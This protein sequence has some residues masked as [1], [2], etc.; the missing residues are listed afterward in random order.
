MNFAKILSALALSSFAIVTG[1]TAQTASTESTASEQAA[2]KSCTGL[3]QSQCEAD[4][5][6]MEKDVSCV[7][8]CT[9]NEGCVNKCTTACAPLDCSALS[10]GDCTTYSGNQCQL[11]KACVVTCK[12]GAEGGCTT[13]CS[14]SCVP[15]VVDCANLDQSECSANGSY[16]TSVPGACLVSCTVNEGCVTKCAA[17]TCAAISN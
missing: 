14:D 11:E 10:N 8:T 12:T 7:V 4:K 13:T 16:C 2:V 3:S 1:C 15:A 6:C 17:P 5:G 9:V